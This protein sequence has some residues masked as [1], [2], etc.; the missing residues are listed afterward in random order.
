MTGASLV[1]YKWS[2]TNA[3]KDELMRKL[4][5]NR[6]SAVAIVL[7]LAL[8]N[9]SCSSERSRNGAV[10]PNGEPV[11]TLMEFS[12]PLELSHLPAGWNHVMFKLH[13]PMD[14][15]FA[16][17]EGLDAI[18]LSTE[19]SAS[20]LFRQVDFSLDEYPT[21]SWHWLI[22]K[23]IDVIYD[24]TTAG[25]D[26]HPARIY[27]TFE[28]IEGK[29]RSMQLVWAGQQL[30]TGDYK[31]LSYLFDLIGPYT[32]YVVR[33]RS[34]EIGV[35]YH[36]RINLQEIYENGIGDTTAVRLVEIALFSDT[37]QT[38]NSSVV[39]FGPIKIHHL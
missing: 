26:D 2:L 38:D 4:A 33:D 28:N 13:G 25:G 31:Q 16:K 10:K 14:I 32:H 19:N 23:N 18:R 39:Y 37:D 22:E 7:A 20:M 3:L 12:E 21:L 30:N 8:L 24:E 5:G 35:W 34:D 15:S 29:R 1:A 27:M 17:K 11:I 9:A 36:E 6:L